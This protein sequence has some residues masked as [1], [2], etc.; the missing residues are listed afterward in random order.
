MRRLGW[1]P[2]LAVC[3]S[4]SDSTVS[5]N[6]AFAE[7]YTGDYTT[8]SSPG[9]GFRAT[10]IMSVTEPSRLEG[11]LS[12][13]SNTLPLPFSATYAQD[14]VTPF[15][16]APLPYFAKGIAKLTVV[17]GGGNQLV[18]PMIGTDGAFAGETFSFDLHSY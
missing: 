12:L 11:T 13:P 16:V 9:H 7:I 17:E 4:C 2:L 15:V 5:P 18:G 3:S 14:T 8:S 10:L 1:L 6:V